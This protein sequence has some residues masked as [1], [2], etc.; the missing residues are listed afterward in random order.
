MISAKWEASDIGVDQSLRGEREMM[1]GIKKPS[2][3]ERR[4][5]H[6]QAIRVTAVEALSPSRWFE[7]SRRA[8]SSQSSSLWS[9][10]RKLT[11][12][13]LLRG[14]SSFLSRCFFFCYLRC[15]FPFLNVLCSQKVLLTY[16]SSSLGSSALIC[17]FCRLS[18]QRSSSSFRLLSRF[19]VASID[20]CF[21]PDTL[22][23][24]NDAMFSF[25]ML[26]CS[27][28]LRLCVSMIPLSRSVLPHKQ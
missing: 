5:E 27:I 6:S 11:L 1:R 14:I 9:Y 8:S 3:L 13:L 20:S 21:S 7:S 25:S 2:V 15:F 22:L 28:V 26:C 16:S 4:K 23:S 12:T 19:Y 18:L 10:S 24:H 17:P